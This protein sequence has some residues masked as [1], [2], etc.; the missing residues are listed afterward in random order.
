MSDQTPA[1]LAGTAGQVMVAALNIAGAVVPAIPAITGLVTL[2]ITL[3]NENR[4]PTTAELSSVLSGIDAEHD[5]AQA[6]LQALVT[7]K[8]AARA[9]VTTI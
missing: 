8:A 7:A 2:A 1:N 9:I 4:E 6:A 5:R 3:V